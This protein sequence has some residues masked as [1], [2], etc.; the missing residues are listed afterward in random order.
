VVLEGDIQ[1]RGGDTMLVQGSWD[2]IGAL[3]DERG[4]VVMGA[5][6]EIVQQVVQLT[7]RSW[8]AIGVLVAMVVLMV[9]SAVPTVV[10]ALLAAGALVVT[11][12]V[13]PSAAYRAVSWSS[14]LLIAGMIPMATALQETGGATRIAD[15]VT[16]NVSQPLVILAAVFL[17]TSAFSQVISNSAAAVL[18]GPIFIEA[19]RAADVSPRPLAMGVAVAAS[20]AFLTPIGSPTNLMVL[21]AGGYRFGDYV[22]LGAPVLVLFLATSLVLIPLIWSF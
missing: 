10:A 18:M 13:P 14:V 5:P 6:E 22:K 9:S 12:S 20:T 21:D 7:K 8:F 16:D 3:G 2:R 19:A 4:L 17:L 1:L 11:R 15:A